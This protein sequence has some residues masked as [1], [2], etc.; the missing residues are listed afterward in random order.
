M[1]FAKE[2]RSICWFSSG[3]CCSGD[4]IMLQCSDGGNLQVLGTR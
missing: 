1:G 2:Q 3:N 4:V